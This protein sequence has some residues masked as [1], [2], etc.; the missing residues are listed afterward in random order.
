MILEE[1]CAENE[2]KQSEINIRYESIQKQ[3]K[4]NYEEKTNLDTQKEETIS[5]EKSE[6]AILSTKENELKVEIK[7]LELL[8]K[9]AQEELS[10][11]VEDKVKYEKQIQEKNQQFIEKELMLKNIFDD[12][13]DQKEK[14][15]TL[16]MQ[17]DK[18]KERIKNEKTKFT[19]NIDSLDLVINRNE[20]RVNSNFDFFT[21]VSDLFDESTQT[22]SKE[23]SELNTTNDS[24]SNIFTNKR[25][26]EKKME[27]LNFKIQS[28]EDDISNKT[29]DIV[30]KRNEIENLQIQINTND[31]NKKTFIKEKKF[32]QANTCMKNSKRLTKDKEEKENE[33][34]ILEGL[35]DEQQIKL[36]E[37]KEEL[38]TMKEGASEMWLNVKKNALDR[39]E[40]GR[41]MFQLFID[42][43]DSEVFEHIRQGDTGKKVVINIEEEKLQIEVI[44]KDIILRSEKLKNEIK[45]EDESGFDGELFVKLVSNISKF[46][47][48]S[49]EMAEIQNKIGKRVCI[50]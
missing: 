46:E 50:D 44:L 15:E 10:K 22:A 9:N 21:Q 14:E 8:L 18:N 3:L 11:V 28:I 45:E 38:D 26:F 4:E 36:K 20:K 35:L 23:E 7:K 13:T 2:L 16:K 37:L 29:Q 6:L 33:I 43:F 30:T 12:L 1:I 5:K 17:E 49:K 48:V 32:S 24:N 39:L 42:L 27:E 34:E 40:K 47:Q 31:V 25:K 41:V 19:K